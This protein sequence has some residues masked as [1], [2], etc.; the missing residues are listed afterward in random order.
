MESD[1]ELEVPTKSAVRSYAEMEGGTGANIYF[2]AQRYP[3]R[4]LLER[5]PAS[6][7]VRG[8]PHELFDLSMNGVSFFATESLLK[9]RIGDALPILLRV[10]NA[11]IYEGEG[12]IVR[13]HQHRSGML[14]ALRLMRGFLDIPGIVATHDELALNHDLERGAAPDLQLVPRAYRE[15][16]AD[17]VFLLRHYRSVTE[18]FEKQFARMTQDRRGRYVQML[19]SC[20]RQLYRE[21]EPLRM[22]ANEVVAEVWDDPDRMRATKTFTESVLTP[23]LM[24]GPTWRRSYL[25]PLGY[26]GDFMIMNQFYAQQ[27]EGQS[28]YE[29]IV[30]RLLTTYPVAACVIPRMEMLRDAIAETVLR[31]QKPERIRITSLGS[32]PAREVEEYLAQIRPAQQTHFLLIDQDERALSF[33][34]N[35]VYPI[36]VETGGEVTVECLY[37]SF[38][39]FF[40][41]TALLEELP[42][43]DL[44]YT[45]GLVDYLKE[46]LGRLIVKSLYERLA[47]GGRIIVG[48]MRKRPDVGWVP[49]FTLDWPLIYRT[50]DDMLALAADIEPAAI[51][52]RLDRTGYT[53]LLYV[54][55]PE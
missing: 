24:A 5:L 55:A 43:Q 20:F 26:P 25:K 2:R 50:R 21:W 18:R 16:C 13:Q 28:A 15:L 12:E 51:D 37:L 40:K 48:N 23:E 35:K 39:K 38:S 9:A 45:A 31:S 42:P 36:V 6:L 54:T 11:T 22:R 46:S 30:H 33:A 34:H 8:Q 47:P 53:Y 44:I 49:E 41:N 32:G 3:A 14:V 10:G 27:W 19:E 7:V 29:K 17:M 52:V 1:D 4:E